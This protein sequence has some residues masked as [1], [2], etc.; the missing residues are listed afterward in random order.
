MSPFPAI[1][2]L[3]NSKVHVSSSNCCNIP[4]NIEV[5]V[6]EALR[7]AATLDVSNINPND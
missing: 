4:S 6:D 2:T 5:T 7:S 1:F 3:Q